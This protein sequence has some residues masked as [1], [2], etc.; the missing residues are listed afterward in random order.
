MKIEDILEEKHLIIYEQIVSY[1]EKTIQNAF[2]RIDVPG[3]T[4]SRFCDKI[5]AK[6]GRKDGK[7]EIY[8][9]GN[10]PAFANS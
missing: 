5:W 8:T 2:G 9:R 4:R 6:K 1:I 10:Y 7:K 3:L